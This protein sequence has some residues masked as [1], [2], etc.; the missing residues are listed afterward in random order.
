[1]RCDALSFHPNLKSWNSRVGSALPLFEYPLT[2]KVRLRCKAKKKY[3]VL[4][5]TMV[6]RMATLQPP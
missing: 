4:R 1:M 3:L 6:L 2:I 5:K